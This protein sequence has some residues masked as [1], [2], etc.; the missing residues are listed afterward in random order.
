[1]TEPAPGQDDRPSEP[2]ADFLLDDANPF[3]S[4]HVTPPV[5]G[6]DPPEEP[7]TQPGQ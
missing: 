6:L 2:A 4:G 3:D 1:M 7:E 5:I